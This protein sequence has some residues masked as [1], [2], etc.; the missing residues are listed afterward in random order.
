[1]LVD[2]LDDLDGMLES[3]SDA[4]GDGEGSEEVCVDV[5]WRKHAHFCWEASD[6]EGDGLDEEEESSS[7][8][9]L[10]EDTSEMV[11][12]GEEWLGIAEDAS[13]SSSESDDD[14]APQLI[15]TS[16]PPSPLT[17]SKL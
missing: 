2:L 4:E 10:E 1:L 5:R 17:P 7:D 12:D 14:P 6:N 13:Q 16:K 15:D 11:D 8:E 9:L 3:D